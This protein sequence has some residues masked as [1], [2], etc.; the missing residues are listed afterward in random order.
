MRR[1]STIR[2]AFLF[3]LA[4]GCAAGAE[5][6]AP[7]LDVN[8]IVNESYNFRK[9]AEPEM[10]EEEY[11]LYEK[12]VSMV[13]VQP[14][15]ALKLVE[16]LI[17]GGKQSPAFEFVL[18]NIYYSNNRPDLAEQHYRKALALHPEFTRAWSN[19]GAM[20]YAQERYAD[21]G[22]C[23]V[24]T[25]EG[26]ERDAHTLGLLA[27]CLK[28]TGRKTAAK[29][30]YIQALGLDPANTDYL[31]GLVEIHYEDH[32]YAQAEPLLAE[33]IKLKPDS[34]H[35]WLLYASVLRSQD[36]SLEA[37]AL[38]EAARNLDLLQGEGL[39]LLGDLYEKGKFYREAT[40]TF[41]QLGRDSGK[42]SAVRLI[43]MAESLIATDKLEAAE[44]SLAGL[45]PNLAPDEKLLFHL[46]K[47][48]LFSA[49]KD[50]ARQKEQLD[51]ALALDP[52]NGRAL[53][54]LG[55][56]YKAREDMTRADI[57]L[58]SATRQPDYTSRACIE[59]ADIALKTRRYQRALE[60]LERAL[61][62][63][64]TLP[65]QPYL[66][67]IKRVIAENENASNPQ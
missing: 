45:E 7:A 6:P 57:A 19:L 3:V 35:N 2:L 26:G 22:D 16:S 59:L 36:R 43:A 52:L 63:D 64:K 42:L 61:A 10:T 20:L 48:E 55:R 51:A 50:S 66:A 27:Y 4:G 1:P 41:H 34:R 31:E 15:L 23:L 24:K 46:A 9:N 53:L 47:A 33:L 14:D 37:I 32:E 18:G 40:D 54:A 44:N 8:R 5:K 29:M 12:I 17:G 11:A 21:A 60:F 58:E 13:R 28:K 39:L 30:D 25:I 49:R 38:L 56:F 62:A 65:L 67:K